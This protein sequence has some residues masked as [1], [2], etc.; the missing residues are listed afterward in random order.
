M[1]AFR[2]GIAVRAGEPIN[3]QAEHDCS[4]ISFKIIGP[5]EITGI[6]AAS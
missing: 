1:E 5:R 3:I 2:K 6:N 4:T